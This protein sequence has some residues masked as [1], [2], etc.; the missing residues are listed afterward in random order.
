[1][2]NNDKHGS[3]RKAVQGLPARGISSL[4]LT[5][6][7]YICK[8]YIC[9]FPGDLVTSYSINLSLMNELKYLESYLLNVYVAMSGSLGQAFRLSK[10]SL[11]LKVW[12]KFEYVS[13]KFHFSETLLLSLHQSHICDKQSR[14]FQTHIA[15]PRNTYAIWCSIYSTV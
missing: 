9:F 14:C 10:T 5:R 13:D 8:C 12:M 15:S 7:T 2:I 4:K 3:H 11:C 6:F 1:M